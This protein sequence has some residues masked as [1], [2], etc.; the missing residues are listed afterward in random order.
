MLTLLTIQLEGLGVLPVMSCGIFRGRML[1]I[2][3][4]DIRR[5]DVFK[6]RMF[7]DYR[8]NIRSLSRGLG[9]IRTRASVET[10]A[11]YF[12]L[13]VEAPR[14]RIK[15]YYRAY[16]TISNFCYVRVLIL[17]LYKLPYTFDY[18]GPYSISK[19]FRGIYR[20]K[21]SLSFVEKCSENKSVLGFI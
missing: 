9:Q 11:Y 13:F 19:N 15:L 1:M 16:R 17:H 18:V 7:S 6:G 4:S 14:R 2:D 21:I 12:T 10:Q 5:N 20:Q 8:R 3:V